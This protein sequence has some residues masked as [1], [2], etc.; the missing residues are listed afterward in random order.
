MFLLKNIDISLGDGAIFSLVAIVIV[1][2]I[3]ILIVF[4]V[5]ALQ[6]FKKDNKPTEQVVVNK[7]V[8]Q[9]TPQK[10]ITLED[11]T[12]EDMMVAALI[13]TAE[14]VEETKE[15]DARLVS[16]KQIG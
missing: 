14:F 15:T 12:D 7:P 10:R 4:C 3:L 13:A 16:I 9:A 6:L 2:A 1:F 8:V 5:N 11:I